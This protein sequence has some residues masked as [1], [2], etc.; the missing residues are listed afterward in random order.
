M[1]PAAKEAV[2]AMITALNDP[3]GY[4]RA[5]AATVLGSIG[6]DAKLAVP[7]LI[8]TLREEMQEPFL[9]DRLRIVRHAIVESLG[10]IGS[11][12]A[13]PILAENL[14]APDSAM[15][16]R[17]IDALGRFGPAAESAIP[18]LTE[19]LED[20]LDWTTMRRAAD[21]LARIGPAPVPTLYRN[22]AVDALRTM[23]P[24]WVF[25][26]IF[27]TKT[28]RGITASYAFFAALLLVCGAIHILVRYFLRRWSG[29]WTL[30]GRGVQYVSMGIL[31]YVWL[32]LT[33]TWR[34]ISRIFFSESLLPLVL[35]PTV[36]MAALGVLL[37]WVKP[38][39]VFGKVSVYAFNF[40][41]FEIVLVWLTHVLLPGGHPS[42]AAVLW[43]FL[44]LINPFV[45]AGATIAL[46]IA[47]LRG[48]EKRNLVLAGLG[49]VALT[50]GVHP[51]LAVEIDPILWRIQPLHVRLVS[52]D[53]RM[54]KAAAEEL[55]TLDSG[56]RSELAQQLVESL[57]SERRGVRAK[58][59]TA[60]GKV[61]AAGRD[62]APALIHALKD[63]NIY[64]RSR[65]E[66]ALEPIGAEAAPA[67]IEA[68]KNRH[69]DKSVRLKLARTLGKL[70]PHAPEAV[71]VLIDALKDDDE[72]VR[73]AATEA[74]GRMGAVAKDAVPTLVD[75][76]QDDSRNVRWAAVIALGGIGPSAEEAV[77]ALILIVQD[78]DDPNRGNAALAIGKVGP[79][80]KDAVPSLIHLL[81]NGPSSSRGAAALGLGGIGPSAEEVVPAL[82]Q[83]L[84]DSDGY[85]RKRAAEAL[86]RIGTPEALEALNQRRGRGGGS[87]P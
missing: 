3:D 27:I 62:V 58:A 64:V 71:P 87:G 74:I 21:S 20:D 8:L 12:E 36:I 13:I 60:L 11:R 35:A 31:V 63:E 9:S 22:D 2:P 52:S 1:G 72:E 15:R 6:P 80:A 76:L 54:R 19:V 29:A 82:I 84:G 48:G 39:S 49:Y 67:V 61:G 18:A 16:T 7:D 33:S 65:A 78:E 79:A 41:W 25:M 28:F 24:L 53:L 50:L 26:G 38:A 73:A 66:A 23:S 45:L 69:E 46:C 68:L 37:F 42:L 47:G 75:L 55:T 86:T 32:N 4:H 14:Q 85:V 17:A 57:R 43:L 40:L 10:K 59:A 30:V 5:S 56:S 44:G 81:H 70:R 51:T 34:E 77:P 83:A